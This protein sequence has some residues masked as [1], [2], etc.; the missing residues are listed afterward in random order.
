[1]KHYRMLAEMFLSEDDVPR[2]VTYYVDV[3]VAPESI[4]DEAGRHGIAI[5]IGFLD[6]QGNSVYRLQGS[7]AAIKS[8][9]RKLGI[10]RYLTPAD[11]IVRD[12]DIDDDHG[13]T[14]SLY[15]N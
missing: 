13:N 5:D 10:N 12:P 8:F 14:D 4:E 7:D 2:H 1:M 9:F 11:G 3:D 6:R 15:G